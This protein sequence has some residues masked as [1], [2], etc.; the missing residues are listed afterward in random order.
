MKYSEDEVLQFVEE[1]D[2][3]FVRLAFCDVFGRSKNVAILADELPRAFT[4]GIAI[5]GSS[6]AGFGGVE[7]SDLLLFPHAETIAELP[8]RPDTGKVVRMFCDVRTPDG[9][10]FEND[11]R[12]VLMGAIEAAKEAG[13][14]FMFG[15][16][17]E[18][19]LFKTDDLGR[20]TA[21]PYD[22]AGYM[23]IAPD[24]KGEN[25]RREIC[26]T[27][28][29]MGI[30]PESS[31]HEMGPGQNEI[32]FRY[33]DAL[34][35]ADNAITFKSVVRTV[36]ASNGLVADFSPKPLAGAP[37]NGVHVNF[38][39]RKAEGSGAVAGGE[40]GRSADADRMALTR[41]AAAG[42]MR[43]IREITLFL[44][45]TEN[46]YDRLGED[47]APAYVSWSAQNRSQLI[48]IPAAV[49]PYRRAE[50]RSADASSNPYLV[51]ALLIFA[52]LEGIADELMLPE[53]ANFDMFS[54]PEEILGTYERLPET[55]A[56]AKEKARTS[57][58]VDAHLPASLVDTY[59]GR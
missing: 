47:K 56:E 3:K 26:L 16:E 42:I 55:L 18:F 17:M 7:K 25:V 48:R 34:T 14:E 41:A 33:A 31:H 1:D 30:H 23:D 21:E 40:A 49:G 5:D 29:R 20:P 43:R 45:P 11:T 38:S 28:E 58:F 36:A 52:G 57:A 50:L 46:S 39:V 37:G 27:L 2:V 51:F 13:V 15:P 4:Y 19:Y 6:I 59:C 35:A 32:D 44:N 24:D 54:A 22:H 10:A 8:W 53:P 12:Q 9:E